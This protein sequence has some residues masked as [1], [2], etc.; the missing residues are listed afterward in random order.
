MAVLL[1]ATS[2]VLMGL[3]LTV[4]SICS[5]I[6]HLLRSRKPRRGFLGKFHYRVQHGRL[7]HPAKFEEANVVPY[8]QACISKAPRFHPAGGMILPPVASHAWDVAHNFI[9]DSS[10]KKVS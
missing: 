8:L 10:N 1:M 9:R 3:Y 7:P 5:I 2:N 4:L 6:C